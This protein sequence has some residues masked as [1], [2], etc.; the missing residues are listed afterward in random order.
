MVAAG[1]VYIIAP[2]CRSDDFAEADHTFTFLSNGDDGFM[3]VQGTTSFV[4]IDAVAI[5][6]ATQVGVQ[7]SPRTQTTPSFEVLCACRQRR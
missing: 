3:L 1:D 2:F 4:Q 6:M 5:G 7:G